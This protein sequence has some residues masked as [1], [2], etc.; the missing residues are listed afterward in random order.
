M[1][2][3]YEF[4]YPT[5]NSQTKFVL[6]SPIAELISVYKNGDKDHPISFTP[7]TELVIENGTKAVYE[8]FD[9]KRV[10]LETEKLFLND[11]ESNNE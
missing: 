7:G 1:A 6:R 2:S 9:A 8:K 3:V 5:E 11:E 4:I 10:S